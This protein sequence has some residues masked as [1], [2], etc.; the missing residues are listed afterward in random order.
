MAEKS[1]LLGGNTGEYVPKTDGRASWY[2]KCAVE[3]YAGGQVLRSYNTLV[4]A[5][6]NDG[7]L[8]RLWGGWSAT[9]GRHIRAWA[10]LN[11]AE[12][13]A[14]PFGRVDWAGEQSRVVY[15]GA[16]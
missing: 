3:T 2:G 16:E 9:T 8:V 14:L 12:W 1:F 5:R 10:G 11:K 4:L 13:N 15:G 7:T 6:S